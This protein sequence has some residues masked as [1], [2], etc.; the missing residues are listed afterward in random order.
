MSDALNR[1]LGLD[2]LRFGDGVTRLGWAHPIPAW[3]W[4]LIV[5]AAILLAGWSYARL[6]GP[7]AARTALACV[8]ALV[9]VLIALLA[10]GPRLQ[11]ERTEVEPDRLVVLLD[12]SASLGIADTGGASRDDELRTSLTD[13]AAM[14]K[15]L[16]GEKSIVWLGFDHAVSELTTDKDGVPASLPPAEGQRTTIGAAIEEARRRTAGHPLSGIVVISDGRSSDE[17]TPEARR[18]LQADRVPV[19]VV[20]LGSD[21]RGADFAVHSASAPTVAYVDDTIPVSVRFGG[22]IVDQ[23]SLGTLE[24]TDAATGLVLERHELTPD[25]FAAG[26]VTIPAKAPTAGEQ[27]WRVRYVPSGPDLAPQN[28]MATFA[29]RFVDQPIRV[30]YV[31]GSPRWEERYLKSLLIR[32]DSIESSCLLLAVNRRYQQ[33]G[34][35]VLSELPQSAEDWDG[36][37]AIIIGDLDPGLFGERTLENIRDHVGQQGA[38]LLWLA[39][40][41]ATPYA[42][43]DTPLADLLPVAAAGP[44]GSPAALWSDPVVMKPTPLGKRLGLFADDASFAGVE[45]ASAGWSALRWALRIEPGTLKAA[46]ETLA[47]AVP[48]DS[49]D[50][51][52]PLVV[53]MRYGAGRTALVATDEIWRWRYGRGEPPTERFWL[54]LLRMLARPRLASIGAAATLNVTPPIADAGQVV[55]VELTIVDQSVAEIAPKELNAVVSRTPTGSFAPRT[56]R[57][58]REPDGGTGRARYS[59]TF[60]ALDPGAFSVNVAPDQLA[61]IRLESPLEVIAPDDELRNPQTDHP[62]LTEIADATGGKVLT[63]DELDSL[64][65]LLPNR[66]LIVPLPPESATLWDRPVSLIVLLVLLTVEWVGRRLIRLT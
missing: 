39:G 37:D 5:L 53:S 63:L 59:T 45:D 48:T 55:S 60:P 12:R 52:G 64:P 30:L 40:P 7:V 43:G 26:E 42:W 9:L 29:V 6:Q 35:T 61:G 18:D 17:L 14:W 46:A 22:E 58:V 24:L 32:E 20:P 51:G 41:T 28:N 34:D 33:E 49:A 11:R 16:A 27:R 57:L 19:D 31:D 8:R 47:L 13:H 56:I 38:A 3:A 1:M 50:E 54:P 21:E 15:K 10:A 65:G 2:A 25:E 23:A 62:F 44:A 66:R 36:F 4:L